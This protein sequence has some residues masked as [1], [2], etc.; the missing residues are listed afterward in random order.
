MHPSFAGTWSLD[1]QK[2]DFGRIPGGAPQLID[3]VTQE[4]AL[5]T[6]RRE[7]NGEAVTLRIPLDGSTGD[8][9]IRGMQMAVQ[10]HWE[11]RTLVINYSGSR[12]GNPVTSEEK[13]SLAPDGNV[14]VVKRHMSGMPGATDQS[15]YM[16]KQK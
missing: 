15:L 8:V 9:Q 13:W 2:S 5:L 10:T 6:I 16:V 7:R 1:K 11:E 12:G 4:P 3:T 14:I